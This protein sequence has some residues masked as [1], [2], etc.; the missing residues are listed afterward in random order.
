MLCKLKELNIILKYGG[1]ITWTN[2][3][4]YFSP[5]SLKVNGPGNGP[6]ITR[7]SSNIALGGCNMTTGEYRVID[8]VQRTVVDQDGE[9]RFDEVSWLA[10]TW[11]QLAPGNNTV[12]LGWFGGGNDSN[13]T[14]VGTWRDAW[15]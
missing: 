15:V 9:N 10:T 3:G 14:L 11:W 4:D 8:L 6:I 1:D 13:S 12:S 7:G 2:Q 5:P